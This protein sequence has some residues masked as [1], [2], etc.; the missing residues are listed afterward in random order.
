MVQYS[1]RLD[2]TFAAVAD[3]TRRGVVERLGQGEASISALAAAFAMTLTGMKKHV[4]I[5]EESG[6]VTTEKLGRVRICRVGPLR[7]DEETQWIAK[8]QE[9]LESRLTGLGEFL[10]RTKEK[11]T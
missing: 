4:R 10:E 7:L 8:Y 9:M 1:A 6:L 11:P 5:L 2:R 3:S